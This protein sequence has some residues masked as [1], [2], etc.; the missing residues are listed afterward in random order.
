MHWL[1]PADDNK[2]TANRWNKAQILIAFKLH[3]FFLKQFRDSI[4]LIFWEN[5][6]QILGSREKA[7]AIAYWAN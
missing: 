4:V 2:V 3:C 7:Y 1:Y 5:I 6:S